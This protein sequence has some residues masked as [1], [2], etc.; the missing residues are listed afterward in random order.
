MSF[1]YTK[2]SLNPLPLKNR[3]LSYTQQPSQNNKIQT[4]D[5][6]TFSKK[7]KYFQKP[8]CDG[9]FLMDRNKLNL[10]SS[11]G[12]IKFFLV[13]SIHN[14]DEAAET[15]TIDGESPVVKKLK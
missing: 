15:C 9:N 10:F 14:L 13:K 5:F 1:T 12:I 7:Q 8:K 4:S 11:F 2:M 6:Q 3:P